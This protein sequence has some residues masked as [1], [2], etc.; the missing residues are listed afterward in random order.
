ME[1]VTAKSL[2]SP[3]RLVADVH[4]EQE[5]LLLRLSDFLGHCCVWSDQKVKQ[6][7]MKEHYSIVPSK[8][9][10]HR[11]LCP[12]KTSVVMVLILLGFLKMGQ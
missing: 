5:Q 1:S 7:C 4:S 12:T 8:N 6:E 9:I 2:R 10:N 11:G 3:L